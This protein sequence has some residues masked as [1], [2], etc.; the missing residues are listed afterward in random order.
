MKSQ[1]EIQKHLEEIGAKI[2]RIYRE[3][4]IVNAVDND[5][6]ALLY[7]LQVREDMLEWVLEDDAELTAPAAG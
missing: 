3:A 1:Q 6:H 5:A 4:K 2:D 7:I